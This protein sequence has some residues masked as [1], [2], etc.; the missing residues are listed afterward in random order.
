MKWSKIIDYNDANNMLQGNM[1][2]FQVTTTRRD[3]SGN[4]YNF[5][6]NFDIPDFMVRTWYGD[7]KVNKNNKTLFKNDP[8]IYFAIWY[9]RLAKVLENYKYQIQALVESSELYYNPLYN[10]DGVEVVT[11]DM[12]KRER[13]VTNDFG[14]NTPYT[15][16]TQYGQDTNT[17]KYGNNAL[18]S[19]TVQYGE[20]TT[21][22]K[23]SPFDETSAQYPQGST[24]TGTH[25]DTTTHNPHTDVNER[26]MHTDTATFNPHTDVNERS[27]HTD[28]TTFNPHT[29]KEKIAD[30]AYK[31]TITTKRAGNIGVTKSTDL[32]E[33][34]RNVAIEYYRPV[35]DLL[36]SFLSEGY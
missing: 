16:S 5:T 11:E 33:S 28:T 27:Q 36:M 10:V 17:M 24:T 4:T 3:N 12:A 26:S 6:H 30:D 15:T 13:N 34:Y 18:Y 25:T 22:E 19:D 2:K 14:N 23:T 8:T 29:D 7:R 9:S 35:L 32:I 1:F 31:N 21:T 20:V